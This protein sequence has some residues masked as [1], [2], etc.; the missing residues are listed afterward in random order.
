[1]FCKGE[2]CMTESKSVLPMVKKNKITL[3]LQW[4]GIS[5]SL[6]ISVLLVI[7]HVLKKM[8]KREEVFLGKYDPIINGN[9]ELFLILFTSL[10]YSEL[11]SLLLNLDLQEW[12]A[13]QYF[14]PSVLIR[15]KT[16]LITFQQFSLIRES[17]KELGD[18][19]S[20]ERTLTG[21]DWLW[22]T[23]G[24]R[25]SWPTGCLD[26]YLW[27]GSLAKRGNPWYTQET[28]FLS[29]RVHIFRQR[30]FFSFW[31]FRNVY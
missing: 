24:Q 23:C 30:W 11:F 22:A 16:L 13:N 20:E 14:M 31:G 19:S 25:L 28:A 7:L 17:N 12:H 18:K 27:T 3:A 5:K 15:N 6:M 29:T 8:L 1:M 26:G 9:M 10:N 21:R 2:H 4:Q